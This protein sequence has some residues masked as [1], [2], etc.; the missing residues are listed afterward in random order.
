MRV[1]RRHEQPVAEHREAAVDRSAA[2]PQVGRQRP[3]VA[4]E[5]L[6]GFRVERPGEVVRPGDVEHA[7]V[8]ERGCF[9]RAEGSGLERPLVG[10]PIH[11]LRRDLGQRTVPLGGVIAA[12]HQPLRRVLVAGG[13]PVG[14]HR[15]RFLLCAGHRGNAEHET[16]RAQAIDAYMLLVQACKGRTTSC[17]AVSRDSSIR[18]PRSFSFNWSTL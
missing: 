11:V 4:P 2:G 3:A 13:E 16:A 8:D 1:E 7:V 18:S 5:R 9:Q 10:E 17:L 15:L 14:R 6:A 12:E